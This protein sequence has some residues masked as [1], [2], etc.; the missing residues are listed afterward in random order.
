MVQTAAVAYINKP[1]WNVNLSGGSDTIRN[2]NFKDLAVSAGSGIFNNTSAQDLTVSTG[3]A[4]VNNTSAY[5][6]GKIDASAL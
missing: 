4:I 3:S 6:I 5:K 2:C 1:A